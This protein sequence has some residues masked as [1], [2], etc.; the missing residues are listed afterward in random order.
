MDLS[1]YVEKRRSNKALKRFISSSNSDCEWDSIS[2]FAVWYHCQKK[3]YKIP[4]DLA[5]GVGNK[6]LTKF[7]IAHARAA[8]IDDIPFLKS[9]YDIYMS[10]DTPVLYDSGR[11]PDNALV[12]LHDDGESVSCVY[13]AE[14]GVFHT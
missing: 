12:I 4:A 5:V 9:L 1:G 14:K 10:S 11:L 6:L 13:D 7:D 3:G 8:V 2:D